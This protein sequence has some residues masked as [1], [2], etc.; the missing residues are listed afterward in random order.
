[1]YLVSGVYTK[2]HLPSASEWQI[3]VLRKTD[4]FEYLEATVVCFFPH[5]GLHFWSVFA[6]KKTF[7]FVRYTYTALRQELC[8]EEKMVGTTRYD[9]GASSLL[10]FFRRV[11]FFFNLNLLFF[12]AHPKN[13]KTVWLGTIN[14]SATN[15]WP[16]WPRGMYQ[17]LVVSCHKKKG[18][19][20][21]LT[22]STIWGQGAPSLRQ[23][24]RPKRG[25]VPYFVARVTTLLDRHTRNTPMTLDYYSISS[26]YPKDDSTFFCF[27]FSF[28]LHRRNISAHKNGPKLPRRDKSTP[29]RA[30]L[31]T[32]HVSPPSA[33]EG[34][35]KVNES[36]SERSSGLRLAVW[37]PLEFGRQPNLLSSFVLCGHFYQVQAG[38]AK[39]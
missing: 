2:L 20:S 7:F 24:F 19:M 12:I 27:W 37:W 18:L 9:R 28:S 35:L 32:C 26:E 31:K 1:M 33:T 29:A 39:G 3:I 25:T 17:K 15:P 36:S 13:Q 38:P 8:R 23:M 6:K 14:E 22:F 10:F 34:S 4:Y 30:G 5:L 11:F 21:F 16:M